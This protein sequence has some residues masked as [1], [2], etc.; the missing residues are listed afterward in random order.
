MSCPHYS[1]FKPSPL[2]VNNHIMNA[3]V[4]ICNPVIVYSLLSCYMELHLSSADSFC[5][6][7]NYF[8]CSASLTYISSCHHFMSYVLISIL[9]KCNLGLVC[10]DCGFILI[11]CNCKEH[12]QPFPMTRLSLF[13]IF[14]LVSLLHQ[15]LI[16]RP[17]PFM[18]HYQ[19]LS[20]ALDISIPT[21]GQHLGLVCLIFQQK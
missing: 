10:P 12:F 15:T 9:E 21:S 2:S 18:V 3:V 6:I 8:C 7:S 13:F 20:F 19:H 16:V 14:P 5:V 11:A 17:R 1:C 4:Q